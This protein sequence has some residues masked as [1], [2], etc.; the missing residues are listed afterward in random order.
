M[1]DKKGKTHR[2]AVAAALILTL[3]AQV[4]ASAIA[5][6]CPE[7]LRSA[8]RL[9]LVTAETMATPTATAQLFERASVGEPWRALGDPEAALIGKNGIGWAH[10]FRQLAR[11]GEPLKVDGDKRA[12]AGIYRIGRSFGFAASPRPGYLRVTEGS[13]CVDDP[14][15]PAYNTITSRARVG[16]TVHGEN[17]WRVP[18]YRRGLLVDYPTDARARAGSCIFIHIRLPEI[19]GT[20]GCIA[21]PEARVAALQDFAEPGAVLAIIPQAALD[22]LPG[23]LPQLGAGKP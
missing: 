13:V 18:E 11:G 8:L 19:W 10:S 3:S 14:S 16:W 2:R 17:M 4:P 6:T 9:V 1:R 12:P 23:C 21:L 15:S 5:Q 22:R 20:S 7:P